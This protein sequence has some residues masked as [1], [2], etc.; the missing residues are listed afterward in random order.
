MNPS[1]I[2]D[3][4]AQDTFKEHEDRLTVA[5]NKLLDELEQVAKETELDPELVFAAF[6]HGITEEW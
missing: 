3:A 1:D 5:F 2:A 4:I 6:Y